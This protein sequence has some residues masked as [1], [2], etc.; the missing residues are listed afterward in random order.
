MSEGKF[1]IQKPEIE[2]SI[3][4]I[5][6]DVQENGILE[7][8]FVIF[9]KN[10]VPIKGL[11]LSTHPRMKLLCESNFMEETY[12]VSYRFEGSYLEEEQKENGQF[13]FIT[14][15]GEFIIPYTITVKKSSI[16][17]PVGEISELSEFGELAKEY[18]EEALRLFSSDHFPKIFLKR[19]KALC[20]LYQG[21]K[22]SRSIAQAMEEFL[23]YIHQKENVDL[24]VKQTHLEINQEQE[25]Y[26]LEIEKNCEGYVGAFLQTS[27]SHLTLEKEI[28][29]EED[30]EGNC[31]KLNIFIHEKSRSIRSW[32]AKITIYYREK[33]IEIPIYYDSGKQGEEEREKLRQKRQWKKAMFSLYESWFLYRTNHISEET[34]KERERKYALRIQ[35]SEEG[36]KMILPEEYYISFLNRIP[37]ESIQDK[38]KR[39]KIFASLYEAGFHSPFLYYE[40]LKDMNEEIELLTKLEDIELA[41]LRWGYRYD[42]ISER[43][44]DHF[45]QLLAH[46]KQFSKKVF[47]LAE[48]FYKKEPLKEYL[49]I[50]C[51]NLI[52]GDRMELKYH[53]YY[54]EGVEAS[55]K[56]IGLCEAF[57]R[58]MNSEEYGMIPRSVLLYFID[59]N[60]LPD[61]EKEYL[62]ANI[63]Y[64]EKE[65]DGILYQ[66][67]EKIQ[68]FLKEQMKKGRINQHLCYLYK[69]NF[70]QIL[71]SEE[72]TSLLPGILFKRKLICN[73]PLITG[74]IVYHQETRKIEYVP[75]VH[76]MAYIDIYT[77]NY[78]ILF[79]D[80]FG[81]RYIDSISYELQTLFEDSRYIRTCYTHNKENPMLLY[82]LGRHTLKYKQSDARA[83][84]IAKEVLQLQ[85][86][87]EDFYWELLEIIIRYYY[88]NYEG[89]RLEEYL[90]KVNL[91]SYGVHKRRQLM[92]YM[93]V[94]RMYAPVLEAIDQYGYYGISP[95]KILHIATYLLKSKVV[96]EDPLLL[97]MCFYAFRNHQY[98]MESL[99]YLGK[100]GISSLK[101]MIAVWKVAF[102]HSLRI[103]ELEENIL[104]Q[105]LFEEFIVED[106]FS[107][108]ASFFERNSQ[109]ILT[110]AFLR[111]VS[112]E[113]FIAE[114]MFPIAF[115]KTLKTAILEKQITDNFS[116]IALLY[117][118]S[119][120]K[121]IEEDMVPWVQKNVQEFLIEGIVMPFFTKFHQISLPADLSV[122]TMIC[123]KG[124]RE[125]QYYIRYRV[126]V[127]GEWQKEKVREI[128][129]K[130]IMPGIYLAELVIFDRE[131]VSYSIWQRIDHSDRMIKMGI[132]RSERM[133]YEE[134]NNRFDALNLLV[135]QKREE[136]EIELAKEYI[137]QS[138][139]MSKE[140]TLL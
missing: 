53:K 39:K 5:E 38:K 95:K 83:I 7:G 58:S 75:L 139:L 21:L 15:G 55:L 46:Q 3:Q 35:E 63:L 49:A 124:E 24:T 80:K 48:Q 71:L 77:E 115:Y 137:K 90:S 20:L 19:E 27:S 130:E 122:Q 59:S 121:E 30:F 123:W 70:E 107:V 28:L 113:R 94:R 81:R 88:E 64:H 10:E 26:T 126:K 78:Q 69:K 99:E 133:I 50:L 132:L 82:R 54:R 9:S 37:E 12:N 110:K 104:A 1:D 108:F 96:K 100:Y 65:Y 120:Q 23:L 135:S 60:L 22:E 67:G 112:Y 118:L 33:I 101:E 72:M 128:T 66:Y 52:K 87:D 44:L 92:E 89:D 91:R 31:A 16:A 41:A 2:I 140:W 86:I 119:E 111:Y 136:K 102:K 98:E 85:D 84:S 40:M 134:T 73:H 57:I 109:H 125:S 13:I 105:S 114:K 51:G 45:M 61:T 117:Y 131:E 4:E 97:Q 36:R 74:V 79:L 34:Y 14:N 116:K 127:T 76:H 32:Q 68:S 47:R 25:Q 93:I 11:I 62:F 56:L 29:H 17:T 106:L 129:M 42:F 6:E 103:P 8:E 43:L 18:K 138:Q